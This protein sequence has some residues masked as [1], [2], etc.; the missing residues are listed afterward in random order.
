[1]KTFSRYTF[2]DKWIYEN[3]RTSSKYIKFIKIN[4]I[5]WKFTQ[6]FYNA[7]KQYVSL[8]SG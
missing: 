4:W 1:M 7:H 3:F 8:N 5:T 2:Q 6:M